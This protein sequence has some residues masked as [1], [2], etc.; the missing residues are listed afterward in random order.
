MAVY[1]IGI[2]LVRVD[3][4]GAGL[5]RWGTKFLDRLFTPAEQDACAAKASRV[6]CL[7][8]R[9]AAKEAFAKAL[10]TGIRAPLHWRDMEIRNDEAGKP[11][12]VLS[13]RA[14]RF[15]E[16]RGVRSWHVS[17]T[18]DGLYGAAVVILE[19]V[20]PSAPHKP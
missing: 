17:L 18:D 16:Q 3:R 8:M 5:E 6:S 13:E 19:D 14:R 20:P 4:I 15:L 11:T 10:G 7:S 9:F 1:G 2:D 12:L